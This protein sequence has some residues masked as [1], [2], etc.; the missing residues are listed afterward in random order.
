MLN[1]FTYGSFE[2]EGLFS[3]LEDLRSESGLFLLFCITEDGDI[4]FLHVQC[5]ESVQS[6]VSIC[7][8]KSWSHVCEG[9]LRV[10]VK[11]GGK[12]DERERLRQQ[13]LMADFTVE[14][15]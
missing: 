1:R 12:L 2:L 3:R 15:E 14:L 9:K 13:I 8:R 11:Y 5:A 10:A 4:R 6:E 7:L